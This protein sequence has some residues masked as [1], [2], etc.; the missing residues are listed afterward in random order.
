[1]V[2]QSNYFEVCPLFQGVPPDAIKQHT[3]STRVESFSDGSTIFQQ[4][5][6]LNEIFCVLDG[7]VKLARIDIDG[8][9]FTMGLLTNGDLFGAPLSDPSTFEAQES[10]IVKG[11]GS[12]LRIKINEFRNL[13]LNN[14]L[15][16]LRVVELLDS[17]RQKMERR[18]ECFAFKRVELR[19]MQTLRELSGNF[20][21]T[22]EHGFGQHIKLSQ[23][24]LADMVGAT[25][26]VVSTILNRLRNEGVLGYSRDYVCIR[27]FDAIEEILGS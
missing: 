18:L 10:A 7:Q 2:S 17:G 19:L 16:G 22:C 5:Q 27:G 4:G 12:V 26:P 11:D 24:E 25:R 20:E 8:A 14:P 21:Q 1:M 3:P 6:R 23:Q 9:E 15:L 13:L